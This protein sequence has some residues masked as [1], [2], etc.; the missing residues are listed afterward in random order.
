MAG[1][2]RKGEGGKGGRSE[3][4]YDKTPRGPM[5][6]LVGEAGDAGWD[7]GAGG[8]KQEEADED[9]AKTSLVSTRTRV[10]DE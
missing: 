4:N 8:E 6:V 10:V 3:A 7:V 1:G 2:D 9:M 5:L